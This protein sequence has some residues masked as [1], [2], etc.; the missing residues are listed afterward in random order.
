M[1]REAASRELLKVI[2]MFAPGS[3]NRKIYE[4]R[5]ASWSDEEFHDYMTNL[6]TGK[7]TLALFIANLHEHEIKADN[8]N[9]V[10]KYLK[11]PILQHTLLTDPITGQVT[12]SNVPHLIL[13]LPLRRQVQMLYKKMSIAAGDNVVDE[14]TGQA[15]GESK[16][17]RTSYPELQINSA[18][19]LD[20]SVLE[21]IKFRGGDERAY[22]AMN[23]MILETGE[24]SLEA[25]QATNSGKVKSTQ[26]LGVFLNT[27]H[28][29]NNL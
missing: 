1:N 11:Y 26:S 16:G 13:R 15:T 21:Q 20:W 28:L 14:R 22:L 8:L 12:R 6:R 24:A 9:G 19:R 4:D 18:K 10:A 25:I 2:D 7:E 23:K 29:K 5:L 27:A 17:A 3:S